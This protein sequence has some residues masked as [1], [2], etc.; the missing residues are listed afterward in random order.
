MGMMVLGMGDCGHRID[1]RHRLMEILKGKH[2]LQ[3]RFIHEPVRQPAAYP[4]DLL[5]R[6][7]IGRPQPGLAHTR[8]QSRVGIHDPL[9]VRHYLVGLRTDRPIPLLCHRDHFASRRF[10]AFLIHVHRQT[11]GEF[12][13]RRI[14]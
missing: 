7:P 5:G 1:E 14:P 3:P 10:V 2:P 12:S 4:G 11:K 6:Q 9:E 13:T 8:Q